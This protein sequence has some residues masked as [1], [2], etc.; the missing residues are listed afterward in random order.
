MASGKPIDP[1]Y[2]GNLVVL[3]HKGFTPAAIAAALDRSQQT[4][5][6]TMQTYGLSTKFNKATK[7]QIRADYWRLVGEGF[8]PAGAYQYLAAKYSINSAAVRAFIK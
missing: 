7:T 2:L 5:H 8:T 3:L 4:I 1:T 6:S